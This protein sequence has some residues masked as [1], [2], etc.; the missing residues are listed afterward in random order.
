MFGLTGYGGN[1][2]KP[3]LLHLFSVKE[4]KELEG[5]FRLERLRDL[6]YPYKPVSMLL[7]RGWID[8]CIQ[9]IAND[10]GL[11]KY[12]GVIFLIWCNAAT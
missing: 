8:Y 5:L 7:N 9:K 1:L 11:R 10:S 6:N 12:K 4:L 2:I 3:E